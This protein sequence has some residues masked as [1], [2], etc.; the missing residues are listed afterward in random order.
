M[1]IKSQSSPLPYL[2]CSVTYMSR[3]KS[4]QIKPVSIMGKIFVK[5]VFYFIKSGFFYFKMNMFDSIQFC[6]LFKKPFVFCK[7]RKSDISI[8]NK[9]I[10][11]LQF[12]KRSEFGY[13]PGTNVIDST[14]SR[15][16]NSY[17]KRRNYISHNT[18]P[19]KCFF[20]FR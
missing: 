19:L 5:T 15:A 11:N 12:I 20:I 18:P 4:F 9:K 10:Y 2:T 8:Q 1:F 17:Y 16:S 13:N 6:C 7:I 3:I 14:L